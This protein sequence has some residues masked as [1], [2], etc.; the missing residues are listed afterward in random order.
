LWYGRGVEHKW[1]VLIVVSVGVFMSS[2]DLFIVNI[3]FPDIQ[4]SFDGASVANLSWVLN[5][6][7]IIYASLLVPV[8][9]LADRYGRKRFFLYGLAMFVVGSLLCGLAP[10]V[11]TLVAARVLQAAGGAFI[12][13][14]SLGLLLPAF[15]MN[16]RSTAVAIWAAIGGVAAACGPP[17]GGVLVEI[18]WRLIFFVNIP[19]GIVAAYFAVRILIES[20]D[21]NAK[22]MPDLA[23]SALLIF[24]I[25][26]L[27]LGFVKANDW[28]WDSWQ[29][30]LSLSSSVA[31][32]ALF[33]WRCSWHK[34]PVLDLEMLR[35]RSYAM[36][37]LTS[38]LFF[39]G[40]SAMLLGTVLFMT[41][42]WHYSVLSAGLA[43][44][45]GPLMAAS[46][47]VPS[48]KLGQRVGQRWLAGAGCLVAGGGMLYWRLRLG[49]EPNYAGA[50]LPGLIVSGI[51]VGMVIPTSAG[52]AVA[53][54]PPARFAT[55]SAVV[56]M[57]RQ[58]GSVLGVAL[59]IAVFGTVNAADPL[60]A[61]DRGISLMVA[62]E[63]LGALAG[64]GIGKVFVHS[65]FA[66]ETPPISASAPTPALPTTA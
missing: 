41:E 30:I 21:E 64:F 5:A 14:T 36:A 63:L 43:L 11:E 1:K 2:L 54:L 52:A 19:V 38:L 66:D 56:T 20:R 3:A 22:T 48:G 45:P 49:V 15:P 16:Q 24:A 59:L 23:G 8:G 39:G 47:S 57:S 6:Y 26:A 34:S 51:G 44:A 50:L 40:F 33:I 65:E 7:A 31:A 37:N 17:L 25:A 55:G 10:S 42:I 27:S 62:F 35:V 29:T 4:Q 18:D 28:G 53:S 9:R 46:F 61:F 58:I 13:P 12:T 60:A 32:G